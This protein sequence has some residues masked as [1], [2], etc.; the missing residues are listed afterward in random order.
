MCW[1]SYKLADQ[2]HRLQE[3]TKTKPRKFLLFLVMQIFLHPNSFV[4][5]IGEKRKQGDVFINHL[6]C[7]LMLGACRL[8]VQC[9]CGGHYCLPACAICE[10]NVRMLVLPVKVMIIYHL[11]GLHVLIS[12]AWHAKI[13]SLTCLLPSETI[14]LKIHLWC[15]KKRQLLPQHWSVDPQI[16]GRRSYACSLCLGAQISINQSE[17]CAICIWDLM[18]IEPATIKTF[19]WHTRVS[20]RSSIDQIN[21]ATCPPRQHWEVRVQLENAFLR[22]FPL[23]LQLFMFIDLFFPL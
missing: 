23:G 11:T 3:Q 21:W 8:A 19:A 10:I 4:S 17:V 15:L 1:R 14:H 18:N 2:Y 20:L 13:D 6:I 5:V 9:L 22:R 16:I 7:L 12:M